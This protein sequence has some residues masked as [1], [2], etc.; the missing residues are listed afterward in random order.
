MNNFSDLVLLVGTNPLPNYVVAKYFLKNNKNL[1]KIW[2]LHSET[3]VDIGQE[4]TKWLAENIKEVLTEEFNQKGLKFNYCSLSNVSSAKETRNNINE[5]LIKNLS[6]ES[7]VH[8]NYTGGTKTMAVH[9]H[10]VLRENLK[11]VSFSYLDVRTFSLKDDEKGNITEDL[12]E[13]I[14]ISLENLMKLHG[15]ERNKKASANYWDHWKPTLETFKQLIG[16][17]KLQNYLKWKN[18]ELRPIFYRFGKFLS[19]QDFQRSYGSSSF[20]NSLN[21]DLR[22]LLSTIPGE[23]KFFDEKWEIKININNENEYKRRCKETIEGF[24]D[25]KWLEG[26]VYMILKQKTEKEFSR[27]NIPIE[28]NWYIKKTKGKKTFELDVILINGYQVC[29]ISCT[30]S[31][32]ESRCKSKGFEVLHRVNQIGGEEAKA[33]LI[34]CLPKEKTGKEGEK[35]KTVEEMDSDLKTITGSDDEKLLVLGID[36]L[37]ED[38]VWKKIKGFVWKD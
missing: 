2:L 35:I 21:N 30:T 15:Y 9:S 25:G 34:T 27:R 23:N 7:N 18:D 36:D 37:K 29:G 38:K 10:R 24:L 28:A 33:I 22:A 13:K 26:Y 20:K 1:K 4:G 14:N 8:L 12:R 6:N 5:K 16:C 17:D 32:Y 3:R 11:N 19:W 31:N